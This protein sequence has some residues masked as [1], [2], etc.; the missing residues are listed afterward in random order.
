LRGIASK[1]KTREPVC[2]LGRQQAAF[3]KLLPSL[4]ESYRGRSLVPACFL[5]RETYFI[6][7]DAQQYGCDV[8]SRLMIGNPL[9]LC[10]FW[11]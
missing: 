6:E 5:W 10:A 9:F 4:Y 2:L 11:A 8:M 1:T 3:D 7:F